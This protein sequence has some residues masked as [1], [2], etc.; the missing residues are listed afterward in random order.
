MRTIDLSRD[1]LIP[2]AEAAAALPSRPSATALWRWWKK[3][4]AVPGGRVKLETMR[5]GRRR[6]TTREAFR[7]FV[8]SMNADTVPADAEPNRAATTDAKLKAAGVL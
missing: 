7:R 4:V 3:G 2:L 6:F 5:I 1:K 8:E